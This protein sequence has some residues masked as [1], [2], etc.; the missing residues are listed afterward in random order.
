M[1]LREK[2][3]KD[4]GAGDS[5]AYRLYHDIAEEDHRIMLKEIIRNGR[6]SVLDVGVES[7]DHVEALAREHMF[8]VV[9]QL[10]V[11]DQEGGGLDPILS[12]GLMQAAY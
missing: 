2:K 1:P 3:R 8:E 7:V 12:T 9:T 4:G 5:A 6:I 10:D 11:H